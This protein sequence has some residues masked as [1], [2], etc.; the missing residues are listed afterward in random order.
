MFEKELKVLETIVKNNPGTTPL[1]MDILSSLGRNKPVNDLRRIRKY[2]SDKHG[3]IIPME[4][5]ELLYK[6]FQRVGWGTAHIKRGQGAHST[7]TWK[8]DYRAFAQ[9]AIGEGIVNVKNATLT[10]PDV[11]KVISGPTRTT[12]SSGAPETYVFKLTST[13]N[14]LKLTMDEI[15]ELDD[16]IKAVK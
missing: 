9:L 15:L 12:R 7:F 3:A 2:I 11:F 16:L 10:K 6:E 5:M 4:E 8:F 13:G 1:I 14:I